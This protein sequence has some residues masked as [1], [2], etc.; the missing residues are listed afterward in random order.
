MDNGRKSRIFEVVLY[1]LIFNQYRN[2]SVMYNCLISECRRFLLEESVDHNVNEAV[3]VNKTF[4]ANH[5]GECFLSCFDRPDCLTFTFEA[6]TNTCKVY[7]ACGTSCLSSV[8]AGITT[9]K[10]HCFTGYLFFY[11]QRWRY[12]NYKYKNIF[13]RVL[14]NVRVN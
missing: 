5:I 12:C 11:R 14:L 10:R 13:P 9:Y 2:Q 4:I 6:S 8:A 7:T 1:C 3:P